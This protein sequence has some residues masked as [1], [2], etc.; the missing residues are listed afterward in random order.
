M[1]MKSKENVLEALWSKLQVEKNLNFWKSVMT[2]QLMS[3]HLKL[4]NHYQKKKICYVGHGKTRI[5]DNS[6]IIL[7]QFLH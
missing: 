2:A 6:A 3:R 7:Q 5:Y 1:L 4:M